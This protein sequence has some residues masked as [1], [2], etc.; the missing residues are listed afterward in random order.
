MPFNVDMVI[1]LYSVVAVNP[2]G[3]S[4]VAVETPTDV[5]VENGLT[6]LSQR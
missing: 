5:H 2:E 3:T 1:L 6:E 4:Y